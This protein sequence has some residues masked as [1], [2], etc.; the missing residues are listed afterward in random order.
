MS[1]KRETWICNALIVTQNQN[2]EILHGHLQILDDRIGQIISS[3]QSPPAGVEVLDATGLAILPGF[4]QPHIH[5]C[6]TLFRN[7]ADDL[8][9]LDW[10]SDRIWPFEAAHSPDTLTLSAQ[11]GIQELLASGTTCILD[12]GTLRHTEAI[13]QAVADAGLRASLG[14]C[15]MDHP[16]TCPPYLCESTESA[17]AEAQSLYQEWN[18]ACND[19]IRISYAPRFVVSCTEPLLRQ[20]AQMA[21]AQGALIHTHSSENRKEV[22][23]VRDLVGMDNAAYLHHIGLM[24]ERLVLAHCIWL[25]ETETALIRET[26]TH[27]AHCPSSNLKLASGL[28]K[29]PQM[30]AEGINIG[31]AADGAPCNNGLNMFQEMRLGALIHKPA[32]G[33]RSMPASL[34]LDMATIHG[35]KAL[36]WFDQIG[37]L[38]TGKKADLFAVDLWQ[39][40]NL[41][42]VSVGELPTLEQVASALVYATQPAQVAWTLVDGEMVA[43][44]GKALKIPQQA[45]SPE[46][47]H[48]AQRA[49]LE[50]KSEFEKG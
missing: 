27:I 12:M 18:G 9:L 42:P 2:R 39:A 44:Q 24:S 47:V 21:E 15:L 31:L 36:N 28:A 10:L 13:C 41:M 5:L 3:D 43:R 23:L 8:E 19:R 49:I 1:K 50:R 25:S 29:V 48:A 26:G 38:E 30:L 22:E 46:K 6:Q 35:A 11:L 33:P 32:N 16:Q 4:I 40:A 14:K 17:L 7:M 45:L 20:V 37:S 34:V